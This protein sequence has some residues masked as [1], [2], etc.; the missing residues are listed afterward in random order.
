MTA[1]QRLRADVDAG[2]VE[3]VVLALP[4]LAGRLQGTRLSARHFLDST[5][6]D[7]FGACTYLLTTDVDMAVT[8]RSGELDPEGTGFGDMVLAPD[9]ATLRPLPWDPGTVLVLADARHPDGGP[10]QVAPRQ[11][12]RA[13]VEALAGHGLVPYAGV[14]LEFRVFTESYAQAHA[15]GWA[16]LTPATRT[17][18]DYAL[19]GLERMDALTRRLRRETAAAGLVLESARGECAPGQ[20][21]IVFRYDRALAAA[22]AAAF[23]RTAARQVA[24]QEGMALTFMPKYDDAEGNSCHL[25]VSLRGADGTP[26]LAGDG[27]HGES[28]LL[29]RVLAGQLACLRELTLLFAPTVNAYK[30]LRPGAF[31]PTSVAWGPDNR[32]AALRLVGSGASL[33]LEHR[34]PGGDA[35]PYLA[36]AGVL[37][38]ARHGIEED[39][40]LPAPVRG[41]P[42]PGAAALPASLGEAA[43][44]LDGSAVARKGLGDA[45]VDAL[46][47]AA[48]AEEAGYAGTVSEWERARGFE[49]R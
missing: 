6:T 12:L 7:G 48:R 9:L 5:V 27:A 32:L 40:P 13:Q 39:P 23:Y 4:D 34:V 36:L 46:V 42:G 45:V 19:V 17:G 2:R 33:R 8:A 30:R 16:R 15:A 22:D 18:V 31:A 47:A 3:E 35:D 1:L 41:A 28:A 26:V 11:V 25:H 37:L 10:V 43:D 44:A 21:E 14:E 29:R 20:Y 38:A 24:A 49:R